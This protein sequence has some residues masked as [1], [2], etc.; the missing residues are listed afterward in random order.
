MPEAFT[1]TVWERETVTVGKHEAVTVT[2]TVTLGGSM[3][4][5]L[6]LLGEREAITVNIGGAQGFYC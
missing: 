2:A 1:V 3:R 5:L 4:M 6:L